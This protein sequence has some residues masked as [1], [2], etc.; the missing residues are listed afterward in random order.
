MHLL[1][2]YP[3]AIYVKVYLSKTAGCLVTDSTIFSSN[4]LINIHTVRE[5]EAPFHLKEWNKKWHLLTYITWNS[6]EFMTGSDG[7]DLFWNDISSSIKCIKLGTI[8]VQCPTKPKHFQFSFHVSCCGLAPWY[9]GEAET[10][11]KAEVNPRGGTTHTTRWWVEPSQLETYAQ[12]QLEN[13]FHI[14]A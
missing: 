6:G 5:I 11:R 12:V 4:C 3:Y 13:Y 7:D 14:T 2:A 8:T 10:S 1:L 9:S